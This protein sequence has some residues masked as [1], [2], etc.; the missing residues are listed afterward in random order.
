MTDLNVKRWA[1]MGAEARLA[2]IRQETITLLAAFPDLR[3]DGQAVAGRGR[4]AER[5]GRAP[6]A[7]GRKKRRRMSAEARRKISA[8]QKARW[9]KQKDERTGAAKAKRKTPSS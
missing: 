2:E 9:A 8:A 4:S 1:Q 6:S 7:P 3:Q 5:R